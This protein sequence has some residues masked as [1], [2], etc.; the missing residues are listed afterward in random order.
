LPTSVPAATASRNMLPVESTGMFRCF[1]MYGLCVPLPA[2]GGP[3]SMMMCFF[4]VVFVVVVV[5]VIVD[6]VVVTAASTLWA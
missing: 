4:V 6:V 5:V 2:P 1:S 3:K